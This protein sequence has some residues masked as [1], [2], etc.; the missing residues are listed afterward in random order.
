M[1]VTNLLRSLPLGHHLIAERIGVENGNAG[2]IGYSELIH[3]ISTL[4]LLPRSCCFPRVLSPFVWP[5]PNYQHPCSCDCGPAWLTRWS[6]QGCANK[7]TLAWLG[8]WG[9]AQILHHPLFTGHNFEQSHTLQKKRT[10]QD[11]GDLEEAEL[12]QMG[13]DSQEAESS[14]LDL[15]FYSRPPSL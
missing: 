1:G 3:S 6:T 8:D 5:C 14:F 15:G 12:E 11:S 2:V 13:R 4:G 10:E 7:L 9:D